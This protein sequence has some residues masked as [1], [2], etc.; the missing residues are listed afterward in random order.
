[1]KYLVLVSAVLLAAMSSAEARVDCQ[2]QSTAAM[3]RLLGFDCFAHRAPGGAAVTQANLLIP[4]ADIRRIVE[5]LAPQSGLEIKL[6]MAVIAAESA[7]D[8]RAVSPRNAQGLMQLLPETAARFGVQDPFDA[9]D[10]IR[11]GTIYLQWLLKQ[12]D[13]DLDLALAAYNAGEGAVAAY[14]AVPPFNETIDYISRVKRFYG[15]Y[16]AAQR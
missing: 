14:G 8:A 10:N 15:L 6:V 3:A 1:V 5:R 2:V 4:P 9:E 12:F 7:F 16:D 11:G 13:G